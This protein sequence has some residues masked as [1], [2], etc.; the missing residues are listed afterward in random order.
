M[1]SIG[2]RAVFLISALFILTSIPAE[3]VEFMYR[4]TRGYEHYS[5]GSDGR[6][7]IVK[8]KYIG[9]EQY[10]IYSKRLS[11]DYEISLQTVGKEWCLGPIGAARIVCG[12]CKV[13]PES[14]RIT[15]DGEVR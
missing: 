13:S 12:F 2:V 11:G 5:C 14:I 9:P 3:A 15:T 6:G 8:I 10:R 7:G 4:G 1:K